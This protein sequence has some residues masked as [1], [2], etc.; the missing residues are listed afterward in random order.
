MEKIRVMLADDNQIFRD[1][2]AMF[3]A[4]DADMEVVAQ[5]E[6]GHDV[7]AKLDAMRP[8]VICMDVSMAPLNGME[9][10]RQVLRRQPRVKIIG[11][12]AHADRSLVDQ[13]IQAGALGYVVK[14]HAGESLLSAIRDGASRAN[15]SCPGPAL[16]S[17]HSRRGQ[18]PRGGKRHCCRSKP[19][20]AH[21]DGVLGQIHD[22]VKVELF[23]DVAAVNVHRAWR[24]MELLAN[25]R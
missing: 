6:D 21:E 7:L 19:G 5:A 25:L 16:K 18:S 12:S 8:D 13:M 4:S 15:L 23:H 14:D 17:P 20:E 22:R 11:L 3:L 9:T 2:L 10:T 1:A 24:N